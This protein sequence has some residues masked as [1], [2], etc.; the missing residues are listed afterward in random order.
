[1]HAL[2]EVVAELRAAKLRQLRESCVGN[3]KEWATL[4]LGPLDLNQWVETLA[5]NTP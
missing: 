1:M 2:F 5:L 3:A 4:D